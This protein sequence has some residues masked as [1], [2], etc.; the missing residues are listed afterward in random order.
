M[1]KSSFEIFD[2]EEKVA[3]YK[4]VY[5]FVATE[6]TNTCELCVEV[7]AFDSF[8]ELDWAEDDEDSF[9]LLKSLSTGETTKDDNR[10]QIICVKGD[11]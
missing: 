7:E 4:Y 8:D 6:Y 1:A 9:A 10:W 5:V 11:E 3:K 2:F